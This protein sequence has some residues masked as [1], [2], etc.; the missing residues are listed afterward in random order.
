MLASCL[1]LKYQPKKWRNSI[2]SLVLP[3]HDFY[4]LIRDYK[5]KFA[6]LIK[7]YKNLYLLLNCWALPSLV[8]KGLLEWS[9]HRL[10]FTL[11][12]LLS[13]YSAFEYMS[14]FIPAIKSASWILTPVYHSVEGTARLVWWCSTTLF[15]PPSWEIWVFFF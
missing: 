3:W 5:T 6:L 1:L 9:G 4:F 7:I 8:T 2:K 12:M 14:V 15:L 11:Q 13:V 10:C